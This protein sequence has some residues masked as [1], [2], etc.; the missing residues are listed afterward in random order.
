LWDI[1]GHDQAIA[2]LSKSLQEGRVSHAYLIT[3]PASVGKSTLALRLAQA[4]N[5]SSPQP[6]C[7]LCRS[8]QKIESGAH[9]DVRVV[10]LAGAEQEEGAERGRARSAEKAIG[11]DQ[12]RAL[13][14]EV[15]LAPH[16]GGYKVYII[17]NAETL[18]LEA[19]NSLLKVLEEPPKSVVLILTAADANMLLPTIVSRCQVLRLQP[20]S[21]AVI[22]EYLAVQL[23]VERGRADLLARLA[24]GRVGWAIAAAGDD[25]CL[26]QRTAAL[27][28]LLATVEARPTERFAVAADLAAEFTRDRGAVGYALD[29]WQG[30]WRDVLLMQ[31]DAEELVINRDYLESLRGQSVRGGAVQTRAYLAQ[32]EETRLQLE[33][34]VNPRLAL[35]A[36]LLNIPNARTS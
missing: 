2:R 33:Q 26:A 21:A 20:V 24:G 30:R 19:G 22:G 7:R 25:G 10:Q 18:S 15:A 9:L 32:I 3:G 23:G 28:R 13:Q 27:E 31:A 14:R 11:I 29:L 6:P 36:L 12:V 8:C 1:I 34:N 4:L 17:M 5:C 16:E 35:E